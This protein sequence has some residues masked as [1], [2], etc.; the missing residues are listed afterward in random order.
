MPNSSE[1]RLKLAAKASLQKNL[2]NCGLQRFRGEILIGL[3]GFVFGGVWGGGAK[4]ETSAQNK[5]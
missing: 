4:D 5:S 2:V 3:L 1:S